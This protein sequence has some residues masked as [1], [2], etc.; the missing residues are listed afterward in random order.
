MQKQ[1]TLPVV[2]ASLFMIASILAI[3]IGSRSA[4]NG[5]APSDDRPVPAKLSPRTESASSREN[6]HIGKTTADPG[7]AAGNPEQAAATR[8]RILEEIQDASVS[9]DAA[10]LPK[11]EPYLLHADPEIR[12]AAMNGMI[13]L[14][15]KAAGP[16]LRKAAELAPTPQEAVALIEAADYVELPSAKFGRRTRSENKAAK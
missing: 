9:Y 10:E 2:G 7:I 8:E 15:D 16:L 4:E 1:K 3:W 12:Q 13:V 5:H 11:I 6:V 14:G